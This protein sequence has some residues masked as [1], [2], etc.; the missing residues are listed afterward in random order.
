MWIE[1]SDNQKGILGALMAEVS[2]ENSEALIHPELL[3]EQLNAYANCSLEGDEWAILEEDIIIL[4]HVMN[5]LNVD[6]KIDLM[7]SL[8]KEDIEVK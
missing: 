1:L 6:E 3:E 7:K 4:R 8:T 5:A 2:S